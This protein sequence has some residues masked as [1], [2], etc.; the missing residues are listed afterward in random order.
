LFFGI[1]AIY[2][3]LSNSSK[4]L[5]KHR[6]VRFLSSPLQNQRFSQGFS[7]FWPIA[8]EFCGAHAG[9]VRSVVRRL[10]FASRCVAKTLGICMAPLPEPSMM[11]IGTLFG[12]GGAYG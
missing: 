11:V 6:K 4:T 5:G 8:L 1:V 2:P 12:I 10:H 3:H 9:S 7:H